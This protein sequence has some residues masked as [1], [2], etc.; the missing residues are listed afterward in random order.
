MD[1]NGLTGNSSIYTYDFSFTPV[2]SHPIG[3][4]EI[5]L[6]FSQ[7]VI[8]Y[9]AGVLLGNKVLWDFTQNETVSG[10]TATTSVYYTSQFAPTLGLGSAIDDNP[11]GP[12]GGAAPVPLPETS[13]VMAGAL[14][15]IP[16]GIGAIRSL[17][18]D[19]TA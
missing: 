15:L 14:M 10:V 2:A 9:D 17:R 6:P 5:N 11:P 8:V 16:F 18:K 7:T 4:F 13:T 19:R 1:W 12:W 3:Q